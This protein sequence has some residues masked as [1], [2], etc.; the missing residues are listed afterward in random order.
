[1]TC[2]ASFKDWKEGGGGGGR[3]RG[4]SLKLQEREARKELGV[5]RSRVEGRKKKRGEGEGLIN[6]VF[7]CTIMETRLNFLIPSLATLGAVKRQSLISS[8]ADKEETCHP[9]G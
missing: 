1:M 7:S 3:G 6:S 5:A 4:G 2:F 9:R 8:R